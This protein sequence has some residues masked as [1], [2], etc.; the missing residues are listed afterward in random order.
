MEFIYRKYRI[1][2]KNQVIDLLQHLWDY[3]ASKRVRYFEWKFEQ[4]PYTNDPLAYVAVDGDKVVA[5]RGYMV[6]PVQIDN[7]DYLCAVLADTVTHP[8]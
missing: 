7:R 1:E 5:F 2:D 3:D 4:N 6:I 8:D